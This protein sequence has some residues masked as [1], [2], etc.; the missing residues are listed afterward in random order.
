[1]KVTPFRMPSPQGTTTSRYPPPPSPNNVNDS[2][3]ATILRK[4][5]PGNYLDMPDFGSSEGIPYQSYDSG[6]YN[7]DRAT[8]RRKLGQ[9]RTAP[10]I[11]PASSTLDRN[12]QPRLV[13]HQS[14]DD[15]VT[16]QQ[17]NPPPPPLK[18]HGRTSP[19]RTP[20]KDRI[21]STSAEPPKLNIRQSVFA[22]FANPADR[23]E[24]VPSLPPLPTSAPLVPSNGGSRSVDSTPSKIPKPV[25]NTLQATR[26]YESG[27]PDLLQSL[28]ESIGLIS[29]VEKERPKSV[30]TGP[31]DY[32]TELEE[33][34]EKLY[35]KRISVNKS[36]Y[37]M[38]QSLPAVSPPD[39]K[40]VKA[41][42]EE[43]KQELADIEKEIFDTGMLI[44][45][46]WRRKVKQD[47]VEGPTHLWVHNVAAKEG[48]K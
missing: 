1:M 26:K 35:S 10:Q 8:G 32:I 3:Q 19:P 14:I 24:E 16:K 15:W 18:I 6:S 2:R 34:R 43:K 38:E 30:E 42:I 12:G 33:T 47:G 17:D 22:P 29:S 21:S 4:P 20:R 44:H 48:K 5:T 46:A 28:S 45:R 13:K 31:K 41:R 37:N 7:S 39:R 36:I 27:T 23:R 25:D 40:E 9:G 11:V